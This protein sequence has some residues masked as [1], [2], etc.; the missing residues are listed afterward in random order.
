MV[1]DEQRKRAR[2]P[3][4]SLPQRPTQAPDA[5]WREPSRPSRKAASTDLGP[6][7]TA[8][9]NC[10]HVLDLPVEGEQRLVGY[11][12][13]DK[14]QVFAV[15]TRRA[16]PGEIVTLPAKEVARLKRLGF[17]VDESKVAATA[18]APTGWPGQIVPPS[19]PAAAR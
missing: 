12:I 1:D 14:Q 8:T 18:E 19:G 4:R 13:A 9:V 5:G 16:L 2:A 7:T 3:A 17:L 6:P 15:V 11:D 10:G